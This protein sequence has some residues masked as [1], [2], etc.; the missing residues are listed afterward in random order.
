MKKLLFVL[1]IIIFIG[2]NS[3]YE[4]HDLLSIKTDDR[5]SGSFILGCGSINNI[6]YYFFYYKEYDGG[7]QKMRMPCYR[8]LIYE[9]DSSPYVEFRKVLRD[10]IDVKI[11]VPKNTIIREFKLN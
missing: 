7:I 10:I 3:I 8:T 5:Y 2:C 1:V 4:K 11:Y 6:D 9:V